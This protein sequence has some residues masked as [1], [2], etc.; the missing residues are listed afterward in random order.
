MPSA[1]LTT[2]C[3]RRHRRP[4]LPQVAAALCEL[5]IPHFTAKTLFSVTNGVAH[6][7]FKRYVML[8][9]LSALGY[10]LFAAVR[11]ALFSVLNNRLSKALRCG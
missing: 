5:A 3:C 7:T 4:S 9:G 2:R 6:D 10:A 11:G 1:Y 8:L